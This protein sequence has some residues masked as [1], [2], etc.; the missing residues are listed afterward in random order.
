MK[1]ERIAY[2]GDASQFFELWDPEHASTGFAVFVHGGFWRT[3]YDLSH[4]NRFCAAL[5]ELGIITANLEYRRVGQHGGGWPGTLEDVATA[6]KAASEKIRQAPVLVG[7]SAGGHLVLRLA[8]E[9]LPLKAVVALAP[10][11]DLRLAYNLNLSSGAV[12][13][14]LGG[15]P[16]EVPGRYDEACAGSHP[17]SVRR[18]IVHGTDDEDV[19]ISVARAYIRVRRNDPEP[20]S[21]LELPKTGHMDLIDPESPACRTVMD[22]VTR[23]AR[24]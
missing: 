20:P 3:K 18:V 5:A 15:T 22:L 24:T 17:S 10:V 4:A 11:A 6:V 16:E 23:F 13:E 1:L 14:F 7:H 8:C 21:L 9:A 2:G 12:R 19:P